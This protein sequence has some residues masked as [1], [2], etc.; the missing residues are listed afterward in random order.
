MKFILLAFV[1]S[2]VVPAHA[3]RG[4]HARDIQPPGKGY[5][6]LGM[7]CASEGG[8]NLNECSAIHRTLRNKAMRHQQPLDSH[9]VNYCT[10]VFDVG[11][12]DYRAW[13]P[14]LRVDTER[15]LYWPVFWFRATGPRAMLHPT[16]A[17][18]R[19]DKPSFQVR[20]RKLL[21]HARK[22]YDTDLNPCRGEPIDWGCYDPPGCDDVTA[23][24]ERNPNWVEIDCGDTRNVFLRPN[25]PALAQL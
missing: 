21:A 15:P 23:Y 17:W 12:R 9:I 4:D 6:R 7:S 8:W 5:V 16:W 22:I 3:R 11:R 19:T 1:L 20:W 18:G 24:K 2:A 14:Q 13:I 10:A 25:P